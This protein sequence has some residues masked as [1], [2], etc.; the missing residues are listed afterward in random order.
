MG[1]V[2][3][4]D[5]GTVRVG[6]AMS[7]PLRIISSPYK[8]IDYHGNDQL[9]VDIKKEMIE[10]QVDELVLGY[11]IGLSGNKTPKTLEVEAFCEMLKSEGLKVTLI[12]ES[13]TSEEA[14]KIMHSMGKKT[15]HNKKMVDQIAAS[16]I[17]K[18]YLNK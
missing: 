7:D 13:F 5:Y 11:P 18:E 3:A 8:T 16:I 10:N 4:I 2:L 15:G 9:V 1:R 12:D 6:L 14:K 17:L